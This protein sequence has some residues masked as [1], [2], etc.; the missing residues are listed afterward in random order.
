ML[1]STI[2]GLATG[3][4]LGLLG[5]GGSIIAVPILVYGLGLEAK[6]AIGTS[7]IIVGLASLLAAWT[8]Y[9]KHAV[10]VSTAIIFGATGGIGS[11]AG[12]RLAQLIPDSV[13]LILFAVVMAF[14]AQLMLRHKH[15]SI[16]A[17]GDEVKTALPVVLLAGLGA[18]L[19]TG[20]IGVGGGFIIVPAL[21][22]LLRM[23]LRKAIGT[24]LLVIGMNS[25]IGAISYASRLSLNLSILP[26]AV[27]TLAAAPLAGGLAHYVPQ[28]KLKLSF[29]IS[30][31]VLSA[32]M[33]AKQV[34]H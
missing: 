21:T 8:H 23:P 16:P 28:E 32:W 5:G 12:S 14:V 24:S 30:L 1:G 25:M 29:S 26:F 9:R 27:A 33:L 7:L 13:Q 22:I 11:F 2:S 10:V 15:S 34:F 19:L 3:T 6:A 18:G 17:D 20:L 31:L 4:L